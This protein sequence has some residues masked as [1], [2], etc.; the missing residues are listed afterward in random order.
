M[1]LKL[2]FTDI[3]EDYLK[4]IHRTIVVFWMYKDRI[5]EKFLLKCLPLLL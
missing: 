2:T 3:F 1:P 4:K 5:L